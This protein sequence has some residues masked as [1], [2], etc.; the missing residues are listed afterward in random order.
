MARDLQDGRYQVTVKEVTRSVQQT[1]GRFQSA[2][3]CDIDGIVDPQTNQLVACPNGTCTVYLDWMDKDKNPIVELACQQFNKAFGTGIKD[4]EEI[5]GDKPLSVVDCSI[6][7]D[8][9]HYV[10]KGGKYA[11]QNCESWRLP[12]AGIRTVKDQPSL[13]DMRKMLGLGKKPKAKANGKPVGASAEKEIP[14]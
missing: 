14:F 8:L 4:P 9:T 7:V 5:H 1:T 2:F 11:G 6:F 13:E 12:N 3:Y 10:A